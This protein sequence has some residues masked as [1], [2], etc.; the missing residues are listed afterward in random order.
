MS[1]F[2]SRAHLKLRA[3]ELPV[4]NMRWPLPPKFGVMQPAT[5]YEQDDPVNNLDPSDAAWPEGQECA[6]NLDSR[7][8]PP[9]SCIAT[10]SHFD[11]PEYQMSPPDSDV[12]S[13]FQPFVLLR[14]APALCMRAT[15][16]TFCDR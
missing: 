5:T 8:C 10:N 1:V 9:S 11:S 16:Q 12:D 15:T 14:P 4:P 2:C 7:V 6:A 3:G 13:I